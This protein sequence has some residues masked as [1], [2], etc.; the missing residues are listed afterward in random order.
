MSAEP[1]YFLFKQ[2]NKN[3][4][5]IKIA[6]EPEYFCFFHIKIFSFCNGVR[7]YKFK[8]NH[9]IIFAINEI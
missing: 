1:Q 5:I 6:A 7:I 2:K 9:R 3:Q 8:S 4:K